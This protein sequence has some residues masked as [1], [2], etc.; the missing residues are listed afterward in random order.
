MYVT[1]CCLLA[2]PCAADTFTVDQANDPSACC[3]LYSIQFL[4]PI[5]QSFTPTLTGL[6]F[7]QF[8]TQDFDFDSSGTGAT[9]T[10]TIHSGSISGTILGISDPTVLPNGFTGITDFSFAT[11]VPLTPATLYFAEVTASGDNWAVGNTGNTYAGGDLIVF[12][13]AEPA[14]DLWFREGIVTPDEP[15]PVPEPG[16]MLLLGSG[17]A[18]L[19]GKRLRNRKAALVE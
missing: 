9:L 6:N 10:V 11:L 14:D 1:I 3:G 8:F 17:I 5:G 7:F 2:L 13:S 4:S 12:G 18:G 19:V 15:N 16:T